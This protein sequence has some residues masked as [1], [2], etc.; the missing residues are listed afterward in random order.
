MKTI[1]EYPDFNPQTHWYAAR[2][3]SG[4]GWQAMVPV[5]KSIRDDMIRAADEALTDEQA[6]AIL[7]TPLATW[8]ENLEVY[9]NDDDI[10]ARFDLQAWR[11]VAV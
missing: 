8:V 4:D 11:W 5:D 1:P 3:A 6:E 2:T 7:T 10:I 9:D